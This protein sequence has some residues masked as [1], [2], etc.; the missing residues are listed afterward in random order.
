[1]G[2]EHFAKS[3]SVFNLYRKVKN[4]N[5]AAPTPPQRRSWLIDWKRSH[6]MLNFDAQD[7]IL[8]AASLV[9]VQSL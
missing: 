1:M 5:C 4:E 7:S 3:L 8:E 6:K 2:F 9:W